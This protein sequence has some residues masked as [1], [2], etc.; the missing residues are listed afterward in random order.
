EVWLST[1]LGQTLAHI[2]SGATEATL[3]TADQQQYRASSVEALTRRALG[4]DLPLSRLTWW[5]RGDPVPGA[6]ADS[7]QRDQRSR[8]T[9]LDQDGWRIA[10]ENYPP[11]EHGGLPRRLEMKSGAQEIRLVID[12]WREVENAR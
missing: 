3:T 7:M 10:F 2:Q 4:W 6:P 1:P 11:D 12:G 5:V 9:L 8:L